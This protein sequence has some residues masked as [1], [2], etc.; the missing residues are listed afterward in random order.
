MANASSNSVKV[1]P[2]QCLNDFALQLN[3]RYKLESILDGTMSFP[4]NGVNGII[5]HGLYGTGKTTMAKLLP[6]LI[7]TSKS[8]PAAH[9]MSAAVLLTLCSRV[10]AITP[11]YRAK[12]GLA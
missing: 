3:S 9:S 12:T 1:T 7:E 4:D 2:P 11:A 6:G 8:D 5:L 10:K